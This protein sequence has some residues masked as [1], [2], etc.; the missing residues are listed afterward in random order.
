MVGRQPGDIVV[1]T[2]EEVRVRKKNLFHQNE[3]IRIPFTQE[4]L[5]LVKMSFIE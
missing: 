1:L 2:V 5:R 4:Y 3:Y